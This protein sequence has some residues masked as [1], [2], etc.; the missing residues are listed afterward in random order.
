M[1]VHRRATEAL[2]LGLS[3]DALWNGE[4]QGLIAAWEAGRVLAS[5]RP[6]LSRLVLAGQFPTLP[7]KGGFDQAPK[8]KIRYG[9]LLYLAMWLGLRGEDLLL[10]TDQETTR[11]CPLSGLRIT[12]TADPSRWSVP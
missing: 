12:F 1:M 4:D 6:D 8:A 5:T 11:V 9:T 3:W 7:W 10:D 2:R